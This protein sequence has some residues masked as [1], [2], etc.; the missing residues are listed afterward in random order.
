MVTLPK[1]IS[2]DDQAVPIPGTT[3]GGTAIVTYSLPALRQHNSAF[4][5]WA[6]Y[7]PHLRLFAIKYMMDAI[8]LL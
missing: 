1:E 4:Q 2:K 5:G 3:A 6:R 7:V 8:L